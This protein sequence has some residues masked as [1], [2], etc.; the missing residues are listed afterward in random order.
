MPDTSQ[1]TDTR[2]PTCGISRKALEDMH[3]SNEA[4][5]NSCPDSFHDEFRSADA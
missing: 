4:A 5:I 1:P 2:C 3:P